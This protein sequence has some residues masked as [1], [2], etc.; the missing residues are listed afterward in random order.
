ML[1]SS[2]TAFGDLTSLVC[3]SYTVNLSVWLST[4]EEHSCLVFIV[5]LFYMFFLNS[6]IIA[7]FAFH[8]SLCQTIPV[9]FI[10]VGSS[11]NLLLTRC[12]TI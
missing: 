5:V 1:T 4:T 10:I 9:Y 6:H 2:K 3:L 12:L 7:Y 11:I 8:Y